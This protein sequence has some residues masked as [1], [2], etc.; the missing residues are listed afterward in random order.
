MAW[1]CPS[2]HLK[3]AAA[4]DGLRCWYYRRRRPLGLRLALDGVD[5]A[6]RGD[7]FDGG[8][9]ESDRSPADEKFRQ[10]DEVWVAGSVTVIRTKSVA[11]TIVWSVATNACVGWIAPTGLRYSASAVSL[12]RSAA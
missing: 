5:P 1:Q 2:A 3:K 4:N 12:G 8:V 9:E 7:V 11:T 10:R 6:E